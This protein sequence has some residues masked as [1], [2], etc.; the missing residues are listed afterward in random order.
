MATNNYFTSYFPALEYESRSTPTYFDKDG[1]EVGRPQCYAN[2]KTSINYSLEFLA[3]KVWGR[4]YRSGGNWAG[5]SV[6]RQVTQAN[7]KKQLYSRSME[8]TLRHSVLHFRP[9][10]ETSDRAL[11]QLFFKKQLERGLISAGLT[12]DSVMYIFSFLYMKDGMGQQY[13]L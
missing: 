11:R 7:A 9:V 13:I 5:S 8:I 6:Y 10:V 2:R 1:N 3:T 4:R 12:Y